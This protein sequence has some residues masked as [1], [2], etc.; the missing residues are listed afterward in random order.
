MDEKMRGRLRSTCSRFARERLD[1]KGVCA[2]LEALAADAGDAEVCYAFDDDGSLHVFDARIA[3][4]EAEMVL[5][6]AFKDYSE[7]ISR[8][9]AR[10]MAGSAAV[11]EM[12]DPAQSADHVDPQRRERM[13]HVVNAVFSEHGCP[14]TVPS[15][16]YHD[17]LL[18]LVRADD[19]SLSHAMVEDHVVTS[20]RPL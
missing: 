13:A 6:G 16:V 4:H 1:E 8:K 19:G 14:A 9:S 7:R 11:A 12:A 18:V 17:M 10:R 5:T 20:A 15:I 3:K 2:E